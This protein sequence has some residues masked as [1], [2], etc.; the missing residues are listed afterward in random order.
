MTVTFREVRREQVPLLIGLA[1]GTGSGK[2]MSALLLARGMTGGEPFAFIDTE[3]GR[4]KH[5]A[6]LFPEMRHAE[7]HAPFRPEKYADAIVQGAADYPVVVVDS[8]SHEWAG[9]GGCLDWHDELMG[10]NQ[11]GRAEAQEAISRIY[12]ALA[13]GARAAQ[14]DDELLHRD[15]YHRAIQ[16]S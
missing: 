16:P 10:G 13:G 2:S 1:G 6:D 8:M 15:P 12:A 9:D 4:A 11:D 7:I 14:E 5:Y 3:N